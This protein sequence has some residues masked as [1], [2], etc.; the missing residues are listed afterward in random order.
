M[1]T[2]GI[3]ENLIEKIHRVV[4]LTKE[5]IIEINHIFS[6]VFRKIIEVDHEALAFMTIVCLIIGGIVGFGVCRLSRGGDSSIES[7]D[8]ILELQTE[9]D[10]LQRNLEDKNSE[11]EIL[12]NAIAEAQHDIRC[13]ISYVEWNVPE[14]YLIVNIS[15]PTE[16]NTGLTSVGV[17][18]DE[19][20]STWH[21]CTDENQPIWTYAIPPGQNSCSYTW[22]EG[23][24]NAPTGFLAPNTYYRIAITYLG[25][26]DEISSYSGGGGGG[27]GQQEE[28][29]DGETFDPVE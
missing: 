3:L 7:K 26:Y 19:P 21:F 17:R 22:A 10:R 23:G 6:G 16:F 11:I 4:G 8:T 27:S 2:G 18:K 9:I 1:S 28:E 5:K 15:N 24:S 13:I 20:G 12:N 14:D 25:G 29:P